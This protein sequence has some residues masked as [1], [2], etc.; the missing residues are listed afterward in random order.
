LALLRELVVRGVAIEHALL[1]LREQHWPLSLL[2]GVYCL[3][4]LRVEPG[5]QFGLPEHPIEQDAN[6]GTESME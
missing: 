5:N 4:E 3:P 1:S 6:I 2:Y